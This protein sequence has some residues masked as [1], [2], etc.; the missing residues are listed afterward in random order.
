MTYWLEQLTGKITMYRLALYV[1]GGIAAFAMLLA[2]VGE[3]SFSAGEV[4]ASATVLLAASWGANRLFGWMYGVKPQGDSALI[5]A[6]ILFCIFSP[7]L[8][9]GKLVVLA[10]V[11][12]FAQATKYVLAIRK[13]HIFN[14]AA[15][16]AV[17]VGLIGVAHASWWIATPALL[18]VTIL[19]SLLVLYK[20]RRIAMGVLFVC[21]AYVLA[22]A[23]GTLQGEQFG[24]MLTTALTSWPL[25]FFA[26]FM[27]SEPLTLPPRKKQQLMLAGI[28]ALIFTAP[29]HIGSFTMTPEIALVLGN[30][31]AFFMSP[32]RGLILKLASITQLTPTT[33]SFIFE[34]PGPMHFVAG[35]YIE[36][37]L[38]HPHADSRGV[39]RMFSIVSVPGANHIEI[40]VKIPEPCSSFKQTLTSL[41]IGETVHATTISGDFTLPDIK[42]QKVLL[43]AGGIG[44]TP[45][46]SQLRNAIE[47]Q[48]Q[49]D[50]TLL[51][52]VA[53][54]D[55]IAFGEIIAESGVNVIVVSGTINSRVPGW[56][57]VQ[58]PQLDQKAVEQYIPDIAERVV[59]IS[60][61]PGMVEALKQL[62][63]RMHA[64]RIKTD[65]FSGY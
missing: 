60:G 24:Y 23:Y 47:Q 20:T 42:Q 56:H 49:R 3:L 40:A 58:Q 26:G 13:R 43:V 8:D 59:Y 19:G 27:L 65:F 55:E 11:A 63:K 12:V 22:V 41:Q 9:I 31:I 57:Y 15:S 21:L 62:F 35:Q 51:Y 28:V 46:I 29:L 33:K 53:T 52:A 17:I 1:L 50:I 44:V 39:R 32:R 6:L 4:A 5:S 25:F 54:T 10:L 18:P 45:F 14:P 37:A 48:E 30:I 2:A 36:I 38:P 34:T 64:K 16:A 7:T 61:P